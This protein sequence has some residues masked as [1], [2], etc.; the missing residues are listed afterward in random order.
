MTFHF[1][2]ER[3]TNQTEKLIK[4]ENPKKIATNFNLGAIANAVFEI[5]YLNLL[6][7]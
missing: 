7:L 1:W 5:S 4:F 6:C 2:W 3:H